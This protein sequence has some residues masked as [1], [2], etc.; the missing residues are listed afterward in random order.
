[1][2]IKNINWTVQ[3]DILRGRG[4]LVRE[5]ILSDLSAGSE[6]FSIFCPGPDQSVQIVVFAENIKINHQVQN[7][8]IL[9]QDNYLSDS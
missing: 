9:I 5:K 7:K 2:V 8:I 3:D 1:M 6:L 4:P